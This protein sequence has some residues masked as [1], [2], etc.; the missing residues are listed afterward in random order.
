MGNAN[1]HSYAKN[2]NIRKLQEEINKDS[3]II[4]AKDEVSVLNNLNFYE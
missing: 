2:G 3:S 4:H 1:A